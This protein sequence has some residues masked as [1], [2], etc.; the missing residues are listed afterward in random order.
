MGHKNVHNDDMHTLAPCSSVWA[1]QNF[2]SVRGKKLHKL[3]VSQ[4]NGD[5]PGSFGHPSTSYLV[6]S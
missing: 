1:F 6:L 5:I 3:V 4:G 2:N